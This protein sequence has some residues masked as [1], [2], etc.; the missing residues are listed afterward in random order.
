L[1]SAVVPRSNSRTTS[2]EFTLVTAPAKQFRI[3][4][5]NERVLLPAHNH[6]HARY[7]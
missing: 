3:I 2:Y 1:T 5:D 4:A 6:L 7:K